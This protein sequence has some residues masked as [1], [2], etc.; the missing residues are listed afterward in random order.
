M[1]FLLY[2]LQPMVALINSDNAEFAGA[3]YL[4]FIFD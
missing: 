4:I 3:I 2:Y 1:L